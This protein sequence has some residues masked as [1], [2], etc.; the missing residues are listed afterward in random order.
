M[1]MGD[2][3]DHQFHCLPQASSLILQATTSPLL[4]EINYILAPSNMSF[5]VTVGLRIL[6]M[7]KLIYPHSLTEGLKPVD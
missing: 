2:T 5:T 3:E 7:W 4:Q 1:R 6:N